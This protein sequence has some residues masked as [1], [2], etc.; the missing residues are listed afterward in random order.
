MNKK[1]ILKCIYNHGGEFLNY[2]FSQEGEDMI[3]DTLL[4]NKKNGF[5][6]DFGALHPYRFSN[7]A[8]FYE[9]GWSGVNVDANPDSIMLFNRMRH[10][11]I[12]VEAGLS[13]N[14]NETL[15][16]YRFKENALSTFDAEKAE[17]LIKA[18]WELDCKLSIKTKSAM[19]ILDEYVQKQHIDF[20][21]I[22]IEGFDEKIINSIDW[23]IYHPTIIMTE[24][25]CCQK[26]EPYSILTDRG[27]EIVAQTGRTVFYM[28]KDTQ[29]ECK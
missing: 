10:R 8:R 12:N 9:R 16:F 11:D 20:M 3:L 14:E 19:H 2:S 21:D 7:T 25:E 17:K 5:Y 4:E 22:D 15:I 6:V 29:R 23:D 26:I 18:G 13:E 28:V 24:R 1:E 27:Y